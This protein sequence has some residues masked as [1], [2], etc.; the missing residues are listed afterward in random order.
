MGSLIHQFPEPRSLRSDTL[1]KEK[2][3]VRRGMLAANF[4][5]KIDD[6]RGSANFCLFYIPPFYFVVI[7]DHMCPS[8]LAAKPKPKW[9]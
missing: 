7:L 4:E 5:S 1:S 6:S 9:L 3:P 2:L 8:Q